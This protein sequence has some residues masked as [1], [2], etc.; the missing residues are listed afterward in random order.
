MF[1]TGAIVLLINITF[2]RVLYEVS[3]SEAGSPPPSSPAPTREPH[4]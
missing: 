3:S 2:T 4:E 1:F